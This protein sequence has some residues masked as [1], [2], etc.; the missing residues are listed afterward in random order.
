MSKFIKLASAASLVLPIMVYA[1]G[2]LELDVIE[3]QAQAIKEKDKVFLQTNA[4]SRRD[5]ILNTSQSMDN[6]VRSIPGAFTQIDKSS[7]AVSVNIRGASGFGRVNTLIDGVSQTFYASSAD[8]GDRG[9]STSQFGALIEPSFL[10]SVDVERGSFSG[11]N[12]ANSLMGATHFRTLTAN[13]LVQEGN[14]VGFLTKI[15]GGTNAIG[16]NYVGVI[17]AKYAIS[18]SKNIGLV[19]GYG[20]R[21]VSQDYKIGGGRK[22]TESSFDLSELRDEYDRINTNTSPFNAA[23]L[24]QRPTSQIVKLEYED[25]V[26]SFTL[27]HRHYQSTVAGRK[28]ANQ[29]YQLNYRLNPE[30]P[31]LDLNFLLAKNMGKQTYQQGKKI[32]GK[33]LLSSLIAK[34]N[35]TTTDIS[36]TL[37]IFLPSEVQWESTIGVNF[38]KNTYTK[39][40]HPEELNFNLEDDET[41]DDNDGFGLS[42]IKKSL[43]SS[44]FQPDGSQKFNTIYLDNRLMYGMFTLDL[45]GNISRYRYRGDRYKY[46]PFYHSAL[47][48]QRNFAQRQRNQ[49]LVN[50]LTRQIEELEEK[51]CAYDEDEDL[52]CREVNIPMHHIGKGKNTN[53]SATLSAYLNDLFTPFISYSKTHRAPNVKEIF[54]S[55]IGDWGVNTNLQSET[56][57]TK[58]LGITGYNQSV[59]TEND[60]LGFK[61]LGYKTKIKDY[62]FNV[63]KPSKYGTVIFHKNYEQPVKIKGIEVEF[64]YDMGWLYTHLTY[65]YQKTNQ[66]VS[67]TDA[68]S[69]V[70]NPSESE[71]L[72]QGF[73]ATKITTLPRDYGSLGLGSRL[74]DRKLEI[75][76]LMKY[77]GKS[78]RASTHKFINKQLSTGRVI[79]QSRATEEIKKQ[80]LVFDFHIS[81]QPTKNLTLRADVQ[82]V[83]DKKYIDPLDSNNDSAS[84]T[85]YNLDISDKYITVLNNYARGRTYIF[86][87]NYKF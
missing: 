65:A 81:Y 18:D 16:P 14:K 23:H 19:Y 27:A 85:I 71:R 49:A 57:S 79:E 44:T 4:V 72:T 61:I 45:N 36:N 28:L 21:K 48:S 34:N 53:Y 80:P 3:V 68:S 30:T 13:D 24:S 87:V 56:A 2:N 59:F 35:A 86:S 15:S 20:W 12:G 50:E 25:A 17:G 9:G 60:S 43:Y 55:N 52:I 84:Q 7:G 83:F 78:K 39:N 42:N 26:N 1:E 10:T 6:I 67:F 38:L 75:G 31:L 64:N 66:P 70:D 5:Q 69:R 74:F 58:Q 54:F 33:P 63:N 77:Y 37:S 73:G 22:V 40:R 47:E 51:Y 76:A 29:N 11:K 82:N 46:V 62:I 41:N 32:I 8:S